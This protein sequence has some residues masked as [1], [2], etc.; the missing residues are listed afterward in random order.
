M[1]PSNSKTVPILELDRIVMRFGGLKALDHPDFNITQGQIKTVIG[2]NG[3]GKTTL[4]NIITGFL[5]PTQGRVRFMG[6]A[7][8]GRQPFEIARMGIARTFQTVELY[9]NMTVLENVMM[10]FH[11]RT[12]PSLL[13]CGL[14]LPKARSKDRIIREESMEIL[15][16]I[17]L[18]DKAEEMADNL[19]L[20]E[21][22]I[23][24]IGRALACKPQL[25]CLDEPA[26]GLNDTET[27]RA[28]SLIMAIQAK[29]VTVLL[30]E[31]D[32]K[33]VMQI[34]DEIVVINYGQKIA[35]G[36]PQE[37]QNNP[38]VLEAYLGEAG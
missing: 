4:F 15:K 32:M 30:V 26:A 14:F 19:P 37:I 9:D 22:K 11:T 23:L 13:A 2:P 17:G 18:A 21:Q 6:H 25:V 8:D 31:H 35:Q 24:E 36:T 12:R 3:A 28:A 5:K 7:I 27:H 1:T 16:F 20:G 33:L 38:K 29:G 10:G 34:S